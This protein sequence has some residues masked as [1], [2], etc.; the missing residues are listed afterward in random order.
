M[1][2]LFFRKP[3]AHALWT[4]LQ[5][6]FLD[7]ADQRAVHALQEFHALFQADLSITDYF[8]VGSSSSPIFFTTLVTPSLSRPW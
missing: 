8:A 6:L 2:M 5:G 4:S 3:M 1:K 7:N